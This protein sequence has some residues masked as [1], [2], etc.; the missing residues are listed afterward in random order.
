MIQNRL[1]LIWVHLSN[2]AIHLSLETSNK[3][4]I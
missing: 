3:K 2:L 4:W 1:D